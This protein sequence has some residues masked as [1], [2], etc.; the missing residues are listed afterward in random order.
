M[1]SL[2]ETVLTDDVGDRACSVEFVVGDNVGAARRADVVILSCH[3]HQGAE[4]LGMP[5]MR[6]ALS[7]KLLVS[8]LGGVSVAKLEEGLYGNPRRS[9]SPG[10]R[11]C[12][13]LQAIPNVAAARQ[14]S[15]TVVGGQSA[16]I[17][18]EVL[19]LGHEVLR[20]IGTPVPVSTN[21]M[22][23][24]TALCASG[25]AF[26]SWFLEAMVD[27]AV[28]QGIERSKATHLA[29]LTMA[30]AAELVVS[31]QDPA[32]VTARVTTPGGATAR[33]LATL[34]RGEA[35]ETVVKALQATTSKICS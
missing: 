27:A 26:F 33:G 34:E 1:Q 17:P 10:L 8:M 16:S 5:G 29:A 3:P 21:Q 7:G 12:H 32:A 19:E 22:P 4:V 2:S 11:P 30:G 25:T 35:K 20:R 28:A 18:G 14:K 15:V 24:A 13:I 9:E 23:A 6:E 31:G